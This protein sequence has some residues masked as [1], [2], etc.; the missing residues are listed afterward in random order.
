MKSANLIIFGAD[1]L[2]AGEEIH[3][4][5]ENDDGYLAYARYTN[6]RCYANTAER[7]VQWEMHGPRGWHGVQEREVGLVEPLRKSM[8]RAAHAGLVAC[9]AR[10]V[11]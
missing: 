8:A 2:P 3:V 5:V 7:T 11:S 4:E 1:G 10:S 9:G 6:V